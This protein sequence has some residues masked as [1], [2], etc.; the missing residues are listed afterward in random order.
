MFEQQLARA[1]MT[2]TPADI[3]TS[4]EEAVELYAGDFLPGSY[5][6]WLLIERERLRDLFA[7]ALLELIKLHEDNRNY[8]L[9]LSYAKRL[10][11]QD[12]LQ[13]STYR[14]LM[15]LHLLQDD[16]AAALHTYHICAA[17]LREE[18]AVE[19]SAS[20]EELRDS[21]CCGWVEKR[22]SISRY[23]RYFDHN[24]I[25]WAKPRMASAAWGV[26]KGAK[27]TLFF[28]VDSR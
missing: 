2:Q 14:L 15:R 17:I 4:L 7:S 19:P 20:T 9:A 18:L 10:L 24:S 6:E 26:G 1:H 5:D 8:D 28:V 22:R 16:Q 12:R 25:G 27:R 11:Y 3:Q 21:D 13:E 23:G